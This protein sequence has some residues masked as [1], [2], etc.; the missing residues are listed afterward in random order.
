MVDPRPLPG[1]RPPAAIESRAE[2]KEIAMTDDVLVITGGAGAMGLACARAL[3]ARGRLLLLD[4]PGVDVT[5]VKRP[6]QK[7]PGRPQDIAAAVA[8][9]TSDDAGFISGCDIR[10][11]G[12]LVGAGKHVVGAA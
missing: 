9:L 7:L 11:D 10:I 3:A 2:R 5:P 1:P 12:G 4:V 6:G 8:F